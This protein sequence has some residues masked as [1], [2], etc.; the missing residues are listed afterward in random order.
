MS[1]LNH[2]R[3]SEIGRVDGLVSEQR[4]RASQKKKK[5]KNNNNNLNQN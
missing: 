5:K 3:D 4:A 1:C 2:D